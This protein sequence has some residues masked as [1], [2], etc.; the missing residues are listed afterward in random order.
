MPFKAWGE[1]G[2]SFCRYLGE[3]RPRG[4]QEHEPQGRARATSLPAK[5]T[6]SDNDSNGSNEHRD[7]D[8]NSGE[9][10]TQELDSEQLDIQS[11][12][13]YLDVKQ[14]TKGHFLTITKVG[15][16]GSKSH[17]MLSMALAP[18]SVTHWVTSSSTA[19]G[20]SIPELLAK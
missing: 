8:G 9:Q 19:A 15:M 12:R 2:V 14:S 13:F 16:G 10:E 6:D 17:L 11:K 4:A 20:P 3:I 1:F 7:D 5:M 18:S